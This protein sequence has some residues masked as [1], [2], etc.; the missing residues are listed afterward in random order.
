MKQVLPESVRLFREDYPP[1][2]RCPAKAIDDRSPHH[3]WLRT[4]YGNVSCADCR[5]P[6]P[7]EPFD[8]LATSDLD[9]LQSVCDATGPLYGGRY[10]SVSGLTEWHGI[11]LFD[12]GEGLDLTFYLVARDALPALISAYRSLLNELDSRSRYAET[13]F[14]IREAA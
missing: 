2:G 14:H 8:K 11:E 4:T 1:S 5:T 9:F 10:N 7:E 13:V 3:V 6:H 12:D